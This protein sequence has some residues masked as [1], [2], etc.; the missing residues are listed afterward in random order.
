M[1]Y[2]NPKVVEGM[3]VFGTFSLRSDFATGAAVG[4]KTYDSL[5]NNLIQMEIGSVPKYKSQLLV[6]E[7]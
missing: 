1:I 2:F 7:V 5:P 6:Q 3:N 4:F